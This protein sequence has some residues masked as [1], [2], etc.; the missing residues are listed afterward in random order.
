MNTEQT[1]LTPEKA[2]SISAALQRYSELGS[3]RIIDPRNEAE[4]TG[5]KNFFS[6]V[7]IEHG[8][9][10]MGCWLAIRQEYEPLVQVIERIATRISAINRSR[11][12][13]QAAE[14]NAAQTK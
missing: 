5:L 13:A 10:F 9:E 8:R 6:N 3:S 4:L 12:S 7:L 14:S 2:Q 11:T 1:A